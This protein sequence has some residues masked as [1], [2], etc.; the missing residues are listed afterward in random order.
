MSPVSSEKCQQ[1]SP[2][3]S[4]IAHCVER[5]HHCTCE[6]VVVRQPAGPASSYKQLSTVTVRLPRTRTCSLP[7]SSSFAP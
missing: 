4:V 2:A 3:V 5:E 1:A 7:S 6:L